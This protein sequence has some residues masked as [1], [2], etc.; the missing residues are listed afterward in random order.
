VEKLCSEEKLHRLH[1][2]WFDLTALFE[3]W[4][5]PTALLE[6]WLTAKRALDLVHN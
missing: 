3:T 1:S 5:D 6:A 2:L 4:F